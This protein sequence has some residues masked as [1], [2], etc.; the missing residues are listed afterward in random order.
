LT[1]IADDVARHAARLRSLAS[2]GSSSSG[3]SWTGTAATRAHARTVTLPPKLDKVTA[4]YGAAGSALLRYAGALA[5]ATERSR[6]A[7]S[8]FTRADDELRSARAAQAAAASSDDAAAAAAAAAGLSTPAPTAPRYQASINAAAAARTRAAAANAQAHADLARA[9]SVA[10]AALQQASHQGIRNKSWWQHVTHSAAHWLSAQWH[11][12]LSHLADIGGKISVIAGIAA[13]VLAVGGLL[14]PP[15]EAAAAAAEGIAAVSGV[16]SAGSAAADDLTTPGHQREGLVTLGMAALP[17]PASKILR[18]LPVGLSGRVLTAV[19]EPMP[20]STP[21][22]FRDATQYEKF[23][24]TLNRGLQQT[25]YPNTVP[26]MQGSSVTGVK[27][28]TGEPFDVGRTSDFD[29]ALAGDDIFGAAAA[30][31]VNVRG[32]GIRTAPLNRRT[33]ARLGLRPLQR[34]LMAISKREVKFMVYRDA[35]EAVDDKPSI[36]MSQ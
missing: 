7:V 23:K 5:D 3:S 32:G 34:E 6:A 33:V 4:S 20:R 1:S 25:R 10:A 11:D 13:A 9:A 24:T 36:V 8:A 15:L 30:A 16:L 26:I 18:R 22:G 21:L 19:E 27:Y 12:A 29:V 35:G 14:F 2:S 31:K 28:T 17:G